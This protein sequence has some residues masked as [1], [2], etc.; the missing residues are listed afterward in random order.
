MVEGAAQAD[1]SIKERGR[2]FHRDLIFAVGENRDVR[3]L[4]L[5]STLFF[6]LNKRAEIISMNMRET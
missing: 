5:I 1:S 4:D 3:Y 2:R 6:S